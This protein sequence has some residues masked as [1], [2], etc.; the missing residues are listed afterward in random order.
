VLYGY[1]WAMEGQPKWRPT[2]NQYIVTISG[3]SST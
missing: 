3:S 2:F 1:D